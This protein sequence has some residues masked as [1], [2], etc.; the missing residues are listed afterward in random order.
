MG[1]QIWIEKVD[2]SG[3]LGI[4]IE[5]G[6]VKGIN[7]DIDIGGD[8]VLPPEPEESPEEIKEKGVWF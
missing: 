4:V 7:E 5:A 2:D 3:K 8:L 1:Y 6:E